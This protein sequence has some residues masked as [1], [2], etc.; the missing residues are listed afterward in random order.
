VRERVFATEN[1]FKH[2]LGYYVAAFQLSDHGY[3]I[4][5]SIKLYKEPD[6]IMLVYPLSEVCSTY[7][8]C[9]SDVDMI[10][11]NKF[12]L[13]KR[14][15]SGA[16][17]IAERVLCDHPS[18]E[19]IYFDSTTQIV[20]PTWHTGRIALLGDACGCLTL[21]AGQ[22]ANMAMA[23]AY[24]L[25]N[26]LER[27]ANNH[28]AALDAYEAF[29]KPH[30]TKRQ[31]DAGPEAFRFV[32]FSAELS[33]RYES[34]P[35]SRIGELSMDGLSK[36]EA[37]RFYDWLGAAQDTQAFYENPAIADLV[38]HAS[39]E[40]AR[41]V[42]E[43]G[44]G[45]GRLAAHLLAAVL[46]RDCLYHAIDISP[47]M[48]QLAQQ[49]LEPWGGRA[50]V[51]VSSGAMLLPCSDARFDRFV[52]TYVLDLLAPEDIRDLLREA[53]RILVPGGLIC[54][55]SLTFGATP[56]ARVVARLCRATYAS[57]PRLV[58]GCRPIELRQFLS[59]D[60]WD[61]QYRN[62]VTAFGVSSEIAVAARSAD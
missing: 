34:W 60:G 14:Q 50:T 9:H 55:V 54:L 22:G 58:G 40:T 1:R 27:Q 19:P 12:A 24:I 11:A 28:G 13:V 41:A 61:L 16:G 33:L 47:K 36:E 59:S 18:S 6:R 48:V 29:M 39:F 51:E 20:M 10:R 3:M 5:H 46:S 37:R 2:F 31:R 7:I 8:F 38:A 56:G 45:T 23:G 32:E 43:F 26:E 25:A 30:V 42:F 53:R 49:R 57:A 35:W 44:C 17:W 52:A 15:Y 4:G 21:V 62:V